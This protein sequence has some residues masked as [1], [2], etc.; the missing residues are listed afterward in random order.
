V[1]EFFE[2]PESWFIGLAEVAEETDPWE[3]RSWLRLDDKRCHKDAQ[4][5]RDDISSG[6][7]PHDGRSMSA[8][9]M[10][11]ITVDTADIGAHVIPFAVEAA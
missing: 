4:D 7:A 5:E 2:V 9:C 8:S 3:L 1:P 10:P 11:A 6:A